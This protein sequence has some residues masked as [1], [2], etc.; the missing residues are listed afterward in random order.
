MAESTQE[1]LDK[2]RAFKEAKKA[3]LKA[4]KAKRAEAKEDKKIS[5]LLEGD[6]LTKQKICR[7]LQAWEEMSQ[8]WALAMRN[9]GDSSG[10]SS[11]TS[12]RYVTAPIKREPP[13][14]FFC[15]D[16]KRMHAFK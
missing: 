1:V 13:P 8:R 2:K 6:R 4:E 14:M 11:I 9:Y 7:R 12:V 10:G 15:P 16:C 5:F 3:R